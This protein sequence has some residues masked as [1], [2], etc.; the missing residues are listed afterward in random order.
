LPVDA[1]HQLL[2]IPNRKGVMSLNNP[3]YDIQI[4]LIDQKVKMSGISKSNAE[5][6]LT[7]DFAPPLGTGAGYAGL[8]LLVMSFASCVSTTLLYLLR[9][10]G[11][12]IS[13]FKAHV[14]GFRREKP[15]SL[16]KIIYEAAIKAD[17][18]G[19][20]EIRN[21]LEETRTLAPVWVSMSDQVV[22]ETSYKLLD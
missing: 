4:S 3:Q 21:A 13:D 19:A 1:W 9:K 11:A 7:F 5:Q 2:K 20:D 16:G 15:L 6:P 17:H 14:Q 8:E 18:I 12:H 10:K 22:V